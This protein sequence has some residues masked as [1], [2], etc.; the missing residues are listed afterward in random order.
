MGERV[1]YVS[2][3]IELAMPRPQFLQQ[4]VLIV[5]R[6]EVASRAVQAPGGSQLW[7]RGCPAFVAFPLKLDAFRRHP[8]GRKR[9]AA[10]YGAIGRPQN[11]ESFASGEALI[12]PQLRCL[13]APGR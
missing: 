2:R 12:R 9:R 8:G 13:F 4:R 10:F 1:L 5:R 11:S 7:N 3:S 6:Q